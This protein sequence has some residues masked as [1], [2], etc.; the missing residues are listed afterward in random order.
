MCVCVVYVSQRGEERISRLPVCVAILVLP[1][2][3]LSS[4]MRI[5]IYGAGSIGLYV[6][7]NGKRSANT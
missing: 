2:P 6:G 4:P 7:E 3:P 1:V 5:G